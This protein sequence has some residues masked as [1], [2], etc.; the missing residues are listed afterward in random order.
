MVGWE[1]RHS[2]WS[3]LVLLALPGGGG[4]G[5]LAHDVSDTHVD[6]LGGGQGHVA[7]QQRG[8]LHD[9][10][11]VA[12]V[13]VRVPAQ[14]GHRHTL[15][16]Q[17]AAAQQARPQPPTTLHQGAHTSRACWV[18][19]LRRVEH[20]PQGTEGVVWARHST[21][22]TWSREVSHGSQK[23]GS[24]AAALHPSALQPYK[25]PAL[26]PPPAPVGTSGHLQAPP[27]YLQSASG[28]VPAMDSGMTVA[29]WTEVWV[30]TPVSCCQ[31]GGSRIC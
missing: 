29:C 19:S 6:R 23:V 25:T 28:W 21:P 1:P 15:E 9:G 5:R 16:M 31:A 12:A 13:G 10:V 8:L 17:L 11:V 22:R 3:R 4:G 18:P 30:A 2:P 20:F 24:Q 7:G 14:R 27:V 26:T